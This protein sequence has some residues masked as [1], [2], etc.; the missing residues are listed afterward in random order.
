[1]IKSLLG[2]LNLLDFIVHPHVYSTSKLSNLLNV[3]ESIW[4]NDLKSGDGTIYIISGFANYNGGARFYKTLKEHTENGGKIV[5]IFGGSSSQR[6]TSRQVVEAL[7][8]CGASVHLINRKRILHAKCY[9]TKSND[10]VQAA[11]ISSGNFTGPGMSQNIEASVNL[12]DIALKHSEFDWINFTDCLLKQSWD[13]Y[14]CF[15]GDPSAAFW[16]L[17]YDESP[18]NTQLEEPEQETL[19][20]TLGHSDT[21]R[22]QA[23]RGDDAGK[24]SQYFWLSKDIF[25]FFP[26]LTIK[27]SRGWKGTLSAKIHVNFKDLGKTKEVTITFEAENNLDFR[28][29]TGPL[30][31]SKLAKSGDIA[32]LS[33]ISDNH[34][35]LHIIDDN[36]LKYNEIMTY[37]TTFVGGKNKRYGF[38]ENNKFNKLIDKNT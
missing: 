33:R 1:M 18:H 35:D 15:L 20:I 12:M 28:L 38:I 16:K 10:G 22:I 25:D 5:A 32:C 14:P 2:V 31:Y 19:I 4:V 11:V 26:P 9:G 27:N 23:S 37:A 13:Y 6:L 8:E 29:G 7:L 34:Y 36:H 21:A 24:G 17:L 30:R 3:L